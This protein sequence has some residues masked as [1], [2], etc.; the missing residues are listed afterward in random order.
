ME[1]F[2]DVLHSI[3]DKVLTGDVAARAHAII[4]GASGTRTQ[5]PEGEEPETPAKATDEAAVP[6]AEEASPPA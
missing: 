4:D 5:P 6:G 2:A 1:T 3:I